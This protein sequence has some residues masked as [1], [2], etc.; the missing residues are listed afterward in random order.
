MKKIFISM[1]TIVLLLGL[2]VST[3]AFSNTINGKLKDSV[4][5]YLNE[6]RA[7]VDAVEKQIDPAND[8]VYPLVSK[9]KTLL[10]LR[11]MAESLKAEVKWDAKTNT[12]VI[13]LNRKVVKI[14]TGSSKM[15]VNG[16]EKK[17]DVPAKAVQNRLFIP[18]RAIAEAFD[19]K[20]FW[21]NRGLIIISSQEKPLG[22]EEEIVGVIL[23]KYDNLAKSF[24]EDLLA[25]KKD[26]K[27][28]FVDKTGKEVIE[29]KYDDVYSFSEGLAVAVKDKQWGFIDKTGK[30]VIQLK[31]NNAY[32]FHQGLAV[33]VKDNKWGFINKSDKEVIELKYHDAY[34]FD[35][36]LAVVVK[37]NKWG[38]IDITGKEVIGLKYD[39]AY[40][41]NE[42]LAVVVKDGKWGFID[43][44]GKEVIGL[45]YDDA[46]SFN[47]GLAIAVKDNKW[48][49]IDKT[50]KEVIEL[51]YDNVYEFVEGIAMVAK[52]GRAFY[53][54]KEGKEVAQSNDL[55]GEE[56]LMINIK[57]NKGDIEIAVYPELMPM[58]ADNFISLVKKNFYDGLTFHRVED[59]VVQGGDPKGDGTGGSDKTIKLETNTKLK[60]IRGAVAMARAADPDSASSQFYI[61]KKDAAWLDGSY[62][63][64]GTVISG[65]DII[66]NISKG[67]K[68][69]KVEEVE[70][71]KP[72]LEG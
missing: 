21:D 22:S 38:Y 26:D 55:E 36:D 13:T 66:D 64:F 49:F 67:D 51:K 7:Y 37:D 6:H 53:I 42:G 8:K 18:V 45:K 69:I 50:G 62:A 41:F 15:L 10:P 48:G 68:M 56:K 30:E 57:T 54:D 44:T 20:V 14:K 3:Y 32:S 59:W 24:S 11:F 19:K 23:G 61:L 65:M 27:C 52:D 2:S 58:T 60:N 4:V 71:K 16:K 29:L 70:S 9:N 35:E 39:D 28:G 46:Y 63:V 47:E 25:V 40:S 1:W 33:V 5:L 12:A 43:K 34:S 72:S 31:Y 17:L